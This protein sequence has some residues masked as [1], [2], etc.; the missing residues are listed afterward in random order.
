MPIHRLMMLGCM[1]LAIGMLA[2]GVARA[3]TL[4]PVATARRV[5][6]HAFRAAATLPAPAVEAVA[7]EDAWIKSLD[8][9]AF[10]AEVRALG[11]RLEREQG[12]ADVAHLQKLIRWSNI[13]A[14]VG[15]GTMWLAPNPMS[16]IALSTWTFSRWTMIAHH[17]CHGGYNR[18]DDG[19]GRF[20]SIGFAVGSIFVRVRDWLDWML[21]EVAISEIRDRAETESRDRGPRSMRAEMWLKHW[22]VSRRYRSGVEHRAQQPAPLPHGRGW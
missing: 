17:T 15:I 22:A 8:L 21:P 12:P 10:K 20:T 1:P 13:C 14:A 19:S 2:S 16:I 11:D 18:Q 4:R 6:A 9:G 5:P 3:P 7:R